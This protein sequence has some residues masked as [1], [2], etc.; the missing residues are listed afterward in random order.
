MRRHTTADVVCT[1]EDVITSPLEWSCTLV[2]V[3]TLTHVGSG[4]GCPDDSDEEEHR[5]AVWGEW[6][7]EGEPEVQHYDSFWTGADQV[8]VRQ[9]AQRLMELHHARHP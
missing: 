8:N 6:T 1:I 4:Y 7:D 5:C 9:E 3:V 2:A